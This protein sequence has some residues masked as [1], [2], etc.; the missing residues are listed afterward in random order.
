MANAQ[1]SCIKR[2][3]KGLSLPTLAQCS[4]QLKKSQQCQCILLFR[5]CFGC[6]SS[7]LWFPFYSSP[8]SS[9]SVCFFLKNEEQQKKT[10]KSLSQKSLSLSTSNPLI[11]SIMKKKL[12]L[13]LPLPLTPFLDTL[14]LLSY[15]FADLLK[16]LCESCA[17]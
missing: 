17:Q 5:N 11:L 7:N 2:Q 14:A 16:H 1:Y 4:G 13:D 10:S 8:S 6:Q 3:G 12:Y 9:S 15:R